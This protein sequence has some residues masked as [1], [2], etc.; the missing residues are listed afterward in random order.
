VFEVYAKFSHEDHQSI[1]SSELMN[2]GA[3]IER[4]QQSQ[5]ICAFST[6]NELS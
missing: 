5:Q 1:L 3:L 6:F 4:A 2:V